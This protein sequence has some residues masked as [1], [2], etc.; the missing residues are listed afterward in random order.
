[1]LLIGVSFRHYTSMNINGIF[2][3]VDIRPNQTSLQPK[4]IGQRRDQLV[5][6]PWI[7]D[8]TCK[9]LAVQVR[10]LL[11]KNLEYYNNNS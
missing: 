2:A 6:Y 9:H 4:V 5:S 10:K 8:P 11:L 7:G 1:M 3:I